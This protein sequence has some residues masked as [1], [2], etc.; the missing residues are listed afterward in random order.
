MLGAPPLVPHERL[1]ALRE[2]APKDSSA[3]VETTERP[4]ESAS[5]IAPA[6]REPSAALQDLAGGIPHRTQ[7]KQRPPTAPETAAGER[8]RRETR[9]KALADDETRRLAAAVPTPARKAPTPSWRVLTLSSGKHPNLEVAEL[10]RGLRLRLPA[11]ADA[12]PGASLD[13]R[14]RGS[15]DGR[16]IGERV[17]VDTRREIEMKL[18]ADWLAPGT[19]DVD[20]FPP[21]AAREPAYAEH[22]A[23][24]TDALDIAPALASE[25]QSAKVQEAAPAA[26]RIPSDHPAR[27]ATHRHTKLEFTIR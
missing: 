23:I 13:V 22:G 8:S 14:V 19:Y 5:E 10:G 9:D 26:K 16:E 2:V 21:Q 4:L 25:G 15:G 12:R 24:T 17:R 3:V 1:A 7:G 20:V 27:P 6:K 18:P 11:P